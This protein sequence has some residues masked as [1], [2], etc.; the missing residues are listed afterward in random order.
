MNANYEMLMNEEKKKNRKHTSRTQIAL[1]CVSLAFTF[2]YISLV[3]VSPAPLPEPFD[4]NIYV[5]GLIFFC[6]A[7]FPLTLITYFG[8]RLLNQDKEIVGKLVRIHDYFTEKNE[9]IQIVKEATNTT[10]FG[11]SQAFL[12]R[13]KTDKNEYWIELSPDSISVFP[14]E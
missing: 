6:L 4:M 9:T 3:K 2:L 10:G 1:V 12:Y 5:G 11:T 7:Y 14:K 8:D 13:V